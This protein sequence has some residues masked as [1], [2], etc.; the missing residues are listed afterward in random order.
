[1]KIVKDLKAFSN[2]SKKQAIVTIITNPCFHAVFNY[3]VSNFFY[4]CHLSLIAKWIWYF[5]RMW[6]HVDIDYRANLAGGFVIKHGLGLV[7]GK[8]VESRGSLVVYQ[9]VTL[10]GSGKTGHTKVEL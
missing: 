7:I 3:R 4:K 5:N 1:M 9:G 2:N 10:G 6:F 8:D